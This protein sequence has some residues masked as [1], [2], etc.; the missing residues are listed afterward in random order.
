MTQLL[1]RWSS[2]R[3]LGVGGHADGRAWPDGEILLVSVIKPHATSW[4]LTIPRVAFTGARLTDFLARV[5]P[6]GCPGPGALIRAYSLPDSPYP[7]ILLKEHA[8]APQ[9][10]GE[11]YIRFLSHARQC[12][13]GALAET[14]PDLCPVLAWQAEPARRFLSHDERATALAESGVAL[15]GVA[16]A[17]LGL[18]LLLLADP[19]LAGSWQT[20][21]SLG[22]VTKARKITGREFPVWVDLPAHQRAL[23]ASPVLTRAEG[24]FARPSRSREPVGPRHVLPEDSATS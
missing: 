18:G 16:D 5:A 14:G 10:I 20:V 15:P 23:L 17:Y 7:S 4:L 13:L 19:A 22:G 3:E 24:L 8:D 21:M 6:F 9:G 12:W 2:D 1:T 11:A